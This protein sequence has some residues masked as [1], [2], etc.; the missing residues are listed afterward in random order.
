MCIKKQGSLR[1]FGD[2]MVSINLYIKDFRTQIEALRY[3]TIRRIDNL[4]LPTVQKSGSQWV[5]AIFNDPRIKGYTGLARMTQRNYEYGE[6]VKKFPKGVFIPGLYVSY[7]T[8]KYF[9][10]KPQNHKTIYIYRDPRDIIVSDYYS[11]LKTHGLNP[12]VADLRTKLSSMPKTDGLL[13]L[14]AFNDKF[15]VMRSWVDLGK[16][17]PNILFLKFE[18]IIASPVKYFLMML[19]H[20]GISINEATLQNILLDYTKDRM[21]E[22]DLSSRSD[23]SESHYR[24]T[25]SS[26]FNEF[27]PIHYKSFY[28]VTG[29][30]LDLLGY[31]IS[32]P[33]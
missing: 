9:I 4:Y 28:E 8:Y 1:L 6:H 11:T 7:Q 17:D 33:L 25:Q 5:S 18:E 31:P 13:Y 30:L 12:V 14:I 20:C 22:A 10:K 3:S 29:N 27:E 24:F 26:H 21:R 19:R 2:H 32:P 16:E 15:S 23:K